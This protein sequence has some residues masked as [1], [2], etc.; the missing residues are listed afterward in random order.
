MGK[1]LIIGGGAAGMFASI[2]AARNGHEVH[3]YEKNEKL[4][5]KLFITGK[6]RCNITNACDM[7]TLFEHVIS[8]SKFLYSAFYGFNN[9]DM[10][11]FLNEIGLKTKI[12]R[13][14]RVFPE[15]DKSSD[16]IRVLQNEMSRLGVK[17][18]FGQVV[19]QVLTKNKSF[20]G[21]ELKNSEKIYGD[22]L[23]IATG[24]ISYSTTGSTG[25]GYKFAKKMGHT[26]TDLAQGL[27][28]FNVKEPWIK[29]LQGLSLKNIR[30]TIFQ[31]KKELYSDFG[32]MLFTHFGVSGPVIISA[33]SHVTKQIAKEP[34]S[35]KIDLKASLTEE[36]LDARLLREFESNKNKQFKNILDTLLPKKMNPIMLDYIGISPEKQVNAISK[37]ERKQII[38]GMKDFRLT[39]LSLRELREAIITRGGVS[40]KD[41]NPSTMES[42]QIKNVHFAGEVM[43]LDALTGGFNLQIAWSTAYAAGDHILS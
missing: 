43:D 27:V 41:I 26:I 16:V 2:S 10:I 6:G 3:V 39:L 7:E 11:D 32:E 42:K 37:E 21:I 13:G 29:E 1:V 22:G 33:S 24:G 38:K 40:V 8:N 5:K 4:G 23:I 34:L 36:Q 31:D 28:P 30:V 17:I 25:D 9:Y 15:S 20:L 18:H 35:L 12:E 19:Q 14:G